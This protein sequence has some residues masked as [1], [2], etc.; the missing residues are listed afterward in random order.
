MHIAFWA[1]GTDGSSWYRCEQ[2]ATALSWLGHTTWASQILPATQQARADVVVG[3]RIALPGSLT[4]WA[5]LKARGVWLVF[6]MDDDYFSI[7]PAH[8]RAHQ[9]WSDPA[10]RNGLLSAIKMADRCTCA[11]QAQAEVLSRYHRDVVV[12][13]NGL[14]AGLLAAPRDYRPA[15]LT[16]GWAGTDSTADGLAM[17]SSAVRRVIGSGTQMVTVGVDRRIVGASGL[18]LDWTGI[19]G[20]KT[21]GREYISHVA[22]FDIW[23]APYRDTPFNRAKFPTKALEASVFGIPLIAS[24]IRPYAEWITH[25]VDGF[26]VRRPHEW[27]G[28]LKALVQDPDLRERIGLAARA[29]ASGHI[30]Q[31]VGLQWEKACT[32]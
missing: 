4:T 12:V 7:D 13:G 18:D 32:F 24:A 23:L 3:S 20:W 25:D 5:R 22:G 30:L 6:D 8:R 15:Q 1:S 28:Y 10:M 31:E 19:E 14:H 17:V 11:S 21:P 29:K 27:G 2:P 26:L 9:F 16:I